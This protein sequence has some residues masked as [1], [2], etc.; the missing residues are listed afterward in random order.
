MLKVFRHE[1]PEWIPIIGACDGYNQPCRDGMDPELAEAM[2]NVSGCDDSAVILSRYL[3]LDLFST[4]S[5]PVST[6]RSNVTIEARQEN[7]ST[8]TT[9]HTPRGDLTEVTRQR[10]PG[11]APYRV[12]H[13][14]E[15]PSQ[16]PALASAFEDETFQINQDRVAVL[17]ARRQLVGDDGMIGFPLPGTPLGMMIRFYAGPEHTCYLHADAPDALRD[18]FSVMEEKYLEHYRLAAQ[19]D[20]DAVLCMDDT[21][22]TTQ[23]PAMFEQYCVDF[24]NK[25]ADIAHAAGKLYLHHSCGLIRDLLSIYAQTRMDSV[26]AFCPPP[27]GNATIREGKEKLGD[28]VI[29]ASLIQMFVLGVGREWIRESV[30]QM[31]EDAAPGDNVLFGIGGDPTKTMEDMTFLREECRKYQRCAD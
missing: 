28:K 29:F 26:H 25:A 13:L 9:W 10:V 4:F 16:I 11:A 18:L 5:P 24:T 30:R 6:K 17:E 14:V 27:L 7:G 19:F 15:E 23:S 1:R 2:G 31:F 8:L 3:D 12:K 20:G 21:S 22:T